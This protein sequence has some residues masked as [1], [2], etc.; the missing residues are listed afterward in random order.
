MK[1][2]DIAVLAARNEQLPEDRT[3]A[4]AA[5]KLLWYKLRDIYNEYRIGVITADVGAEKK[6]AAMLE[7]DKYVADIVMMTELIDKHA[8][9]WKRIEAA[10]NAYRLNPSIET[11][12]AFLEAVY[13]VGR[14]ETDLKT[15]QQEETL[16]TTA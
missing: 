10:G 14:I 16:R 13:G 3:R 11:A 6:S 7:H 9:L 15:K 4:C 5:D 2:E 8:E 12:D 1:C